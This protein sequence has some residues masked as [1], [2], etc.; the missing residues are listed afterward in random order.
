MLQPANWD[1]QVYGLGVANRQEKMLREQ[2]HMSMSRLQ[3]FQH[4]K[5]NPP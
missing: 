2:P 5:F 4:H 1:G 3:L